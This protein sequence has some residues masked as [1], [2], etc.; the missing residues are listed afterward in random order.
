VDFTEYHRQSIAPPHLTQTG[1][2]SELARWQAGAESGNIY[3][4]FDAVASYRFPRMALDA[5]I[6][7]PIAGEVVINS[8]KVRR[9]GRGLQ[10]FK[11]GG[12]D[13]SP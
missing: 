11:V 5:M 6:K 10:L 7:E 2:K 3:V 9:A 1:G 4:G 12:M 13:T 8:N